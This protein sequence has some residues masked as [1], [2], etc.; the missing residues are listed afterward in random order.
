[1]NSFVGLLE[2]IVFHTSTIQLIL[3]LQPEGTCYQ[4]SIGVGEL[5]YDDS[6]YRDRIIRKFIAT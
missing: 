6:S 2:T 5:K 3:T 4:F 1:M